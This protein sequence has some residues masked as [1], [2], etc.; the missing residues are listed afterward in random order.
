MW[1]GKER[2]EGKWR[3]HELRLPR[4]S[5]AVLNA[6]NLRKFADEVLDY[7]KDFT[8]RLGVVFSDDSQEWALGKSG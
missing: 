1:E 7:L 2:L 8:R 6:D 5:S 4:P 3:D